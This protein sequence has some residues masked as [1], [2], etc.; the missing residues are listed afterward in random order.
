[1][2]L[3]WVL[4]CELNKIGITKVAWKWDELDSMYMNGLWWVGMG[5]WK[6]TAL[7]VDIM[8]VPL[9]GEYYLT[10]WSYFCLC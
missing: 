9:H 5:M 8:N 2:G 6:V 7:K 10:V 4:A 3:V 1:M